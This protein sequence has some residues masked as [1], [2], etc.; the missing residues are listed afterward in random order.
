VGTNTG[1]FASHISSSPGTIALFFSDGINQL[2]EL[3]DGVF[4]NT[5]GFASKFSA[6]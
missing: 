6:F 1:G 3:F 2:W 5:G 4:T